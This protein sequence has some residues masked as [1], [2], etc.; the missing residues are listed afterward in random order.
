MKSIILRILCFFGNHKLV[1]Y[2]NVCSPD[3]NFVPHAAMQCLT[4]GRVRYLPDPTF[5]PKHA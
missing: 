4:C 1:K 3:F 5:D 2:G